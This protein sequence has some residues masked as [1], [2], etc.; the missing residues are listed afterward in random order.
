MVLS[1]KPSGDFSWGMIRAPFDLQKDERVQ[2][3]FEKGGFHEGGLQGSFR[4][5]FEVRMGTKGLHITAYI[6]S[7]SSSRH[8]HPCYFTEAAGSSA[9][10]SSARPRRALPR[11]SPMPVGL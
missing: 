4:K 2:G 8:H 1:K 3:G 6:T 10:R 5:E 11:R 7:R 9:T